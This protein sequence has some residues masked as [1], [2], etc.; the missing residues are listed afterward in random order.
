M[1]GDGEL[2]VRHEPL[3]ARV[4]LNAD[5]TIR[6]HDG[7]PVPDF[8]ETT[9]N[10]WRLPKY[11][12][13]LK[14]KLLDGVRVGGWF[15]EDFSAAEIRADIRAEERLRGLRR[16]NS[17]WDGRL[18]IPTLSEVVAL[19]QSASVKRGRVV[20][21]YPETKHPDYFK[22]FAEKKGLLR[23]EDKLVRI[24]TA[25]YK[26]LDSAPV[27]VQSFEVSSL[28]YLNSISALK[29]VQLLDVSG[30]PFDFRESG[31]SR[32]F[33][34][35]VKP[36]SR[37]LGFIRGYADGIGVHLGLIAAP[38]PSGVGLDAT[39][40]IADAHAMGL[41]VHGWTFRAENAFL[42]ASFQR[43]TN[44]ATFGDFKRFV[45][46]FSRLGLDGFF[47]DQPDLVVS[48]IR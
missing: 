45:E 26:N 21:V 36:G 44:P 28:V 1:T 40:L 46:L 7:Q 12:G 22:R 48:S 10:V 18:V 2:I 34:D 5:G 30:Q 9:T 29:L 42:P 17:G 39:S 32:T 14:L 47:S 25:H 27:F 8:S 20:G 43:G 37:G 38:G 15:S 13:R 19:A 24:L 31:D 4:L 41:L 3:L 11:A 33:R 16:A 23:M 35:L 6:V